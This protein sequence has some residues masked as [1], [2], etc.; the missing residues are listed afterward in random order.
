MKALFIFVKPACYSMSASLVK[1][2]RRKGWQVTVLNLCF[3]WQ[4]IERVF[5]Y[6][7]WA[8]R[9]KNSSMDKIYKPR[10]ENYVRKS[11]KIFNVIAKIV[12][13][14]TR[15]LNLPKPDIIV[16][17]T[18]AYICEVIILIGKQLGVP[19]LLLLHMGLLGNN[20][21]NRKFLADKIAAMGPFGKKIMTQNGF[22]EERVIV[23][24]RTVYDKILRTY[25]S[26]HHI[27][28]KRGINPFT[29]IVLYCTD[30]FPPSEAQS[31]AYHVCKAVKQLPNTQLII[32]VHYSERN[33]KIYRN[34]LGKLNMTA[35]VTQKE[36]P[37]KLM[38]ICDV[39]VTGYS[40]T[41]LD[42]ML[43][44]K[45]AVTFNYTEKLSPIPYAESGATW[46]VHDD[47][48]LLEALN[49]LLFNSS[50][51]EKLRSNWSS[52]IFDHAYKLDGKASKRVADLMEKMCIHN[53][54]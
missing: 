53:E 13:F 42:A 44:G 39:L 7:L 45:P 9:I 6:T 51:I 35:Y 1:S 48:E 46:G 20:F 31:C 22:Q 29:N 15:V 25:Y 17:Y 32:Y 52:F 37:F 10:P 4:T 23:T 18:R 11:D 34:I 21:S 47:D 38:S 12:A 16:Y 14:I 33:L 8:K 19:S 5:R 2:L 43:M 3:L 41:A 40:T 26:K 49:Q 50:A 54:L 27:C 24:G 36:N 30:N 28:A